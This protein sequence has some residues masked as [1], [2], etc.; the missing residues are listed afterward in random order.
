[1]SD[2]EEITERIG[3][4]E[5]KVKLSSLMIEKRFAELDLKLGE[6][7]KKFKDALTG[8]PELKEKAGG[9]EDL[10]NIINLGLIKFKEDFKKLSSRISGLEKIP[11]NIEKTM[12]NYEKKL[13]SLGED[14]KK[15]SAKLSTFDT[16]KEDVAKSADEK[17]SS[18]VKTLSEEAERNKME[19][20]HLKKS[21][22]GFS[23][24]M[25]SFERTI[26]LTNLD[27][28]IRRFDSLDRKTLEAQ[29]EID[30]LRGLTPDMSIVEGDIDV[31]KTRLKDISSTVMNALS[32][33]NEFEVNI[34]KKL[35]LLENLTV[36]AE[37]LDYIESIS[38]N[39]GKH[40]KNLNEIQ[41]TIQGLHDDTIKKIS[42]LGN[43]DEELNKLKINIS[44]MLKMVDSNT[45]RLES[46]GKE[47][48][49]ET[50]E[51]NK[52]RIEDSIKQMENV[53]K[54]LEDSE[55]RWNSVSERINK[56]EGGL[57]GMIPESEELKIMQKSI[58]DLRNSISSLN[59]MF[60]EIK[61]KIQTLESKET[62]PIQ[63]WQNEIKNSQSRISK[64]END[65]KNFLARPEK[66]EN[67]GPIREEIEAIK[68]SILSFKKIWSDYKEMIDEKLR[69][70]K[71]GE[72]REVPG[73]IPENIIDEI[74]SLKRIV[75]RLT[76]E[77]EQLERKVRDIRL[78][79][80]GMIAPDVFAN[81]ASRISSIEKK[82]VEIDEEINR[83]SKT[84]PLILE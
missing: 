65:M 74:S 81:I 61:N 45:S 49:I 27:D 64:L 29:A 14:V 3:K 30:K 1:L 43:V 36:K 66:L 68:K 25:K 8:Y 28:I 31:L 9:I 24:A 40:I 80:M 52:R 11:S 10:L 42:G 2:I 34:N 32:R 39:I 67:L 47:D 72:V 60:T 63:N 56:F 41:A 75:S 48:I 79:Q 46:F 22:D 50:T 59:N 5:D 82:M 33:M 38:K 53:W 69:T 84:K 16:L 21:L 71:V 15:L 73:K 76:A 26:E 44:E 77:N 23:S 35:A 58:Q 19:I 37:N 4:F 83:V 62:Q 54:K 20:E 17:I 12:M 51:D 6:L 13:E 70:L 55:T 18:N 7:D 78:T 57:K